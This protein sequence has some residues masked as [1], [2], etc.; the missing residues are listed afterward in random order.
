MVIVLD[1]LGKQCVE[2]FVSRKWN[3]VFIALRC[4]SDG[5][6]EP[7]L[8]QFCSEVLIDLSVSSIGFDLGESRLF[9]SFDD[10]LVLVSTLHNVL[11]DV[12]QS[13]DGCILM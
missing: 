2:W 9:W 3:V 10:K 5:N 4:N 12:C 6:L 13:L 8:L 1:F 7:D 11:G